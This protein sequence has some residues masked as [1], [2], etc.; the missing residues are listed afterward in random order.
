VLEPDGETGELVLTELHPD[1]TA[2]E[3]QNATGWKLRI[4]TEVRPGQP[5]A[6]DELEAL[7]ALKPANGDTVDA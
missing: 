3:A 2:E 6:A 4:A 1:V 7:R 5:P